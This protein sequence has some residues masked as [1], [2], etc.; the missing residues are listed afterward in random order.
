MALEQVYVVHTITMI[1]YLFQKQIKPYCEEYYM[2]SQ[3]LFG[4]PIK[5]K[6]KI[7]SLEGVYILVAHPERWLHQDKQIDQ[8]RSVRN[9]DGDLG[10]WLFQKSAAIFSTKQPRKHTRHIWVNYPGQDV[11]FGFYEYLLILGSFNIRPICYFS[12][13]IGNEKSSLEGQKFFTFS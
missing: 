8:H 13:E 2:Y 11:G 3:M 10:C 5:K 1:P 4:K 6:V 7:N 9:N 12:N